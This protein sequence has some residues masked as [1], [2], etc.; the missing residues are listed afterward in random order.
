[1]NTEIIEHLESLHS[2][3]DID[4]AVMCNELSVDSEGHIALPTI[5]NIISFLTQDK[6]L[7]RK[8]YFLWLPYHETL[9]FLSTLVKFAKE[10]M[11]Y[12]I[13]YVSDVSAVFSKFLW[14]YFEI[15][16]GVDGFVNE[17]LDN[18]LYK[19]EVLD[20]ENFK[21]W[22]SHYHYP[23]ARKYINCELLRTYNNKNK[24]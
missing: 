5:N 21:Q 14:I 10:C 2:K 3:H 1:M 12:A 20:K 18:P 9:S 23:T 24:R 19:D 11:D 6:E 16:L 7:Q 8:L 15:P 13:Y 22:V 4:E 17:V